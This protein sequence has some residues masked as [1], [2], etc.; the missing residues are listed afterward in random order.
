MLDVVSGST[1]EAEEG[2][3]HVYSSQL[4]SQYPFNVFFE[5]LQVKVQLGVV[6]HESD[7]IRDIT[8][9]WENK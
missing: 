3:K 6:L 4:H 2:A 9:K 1:D 7:V 5:C 8:Y